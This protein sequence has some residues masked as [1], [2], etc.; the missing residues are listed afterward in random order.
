MMAEAAASGASAEIAPAAAIAALV[1]YKGEV[2]FGSPP[3]GGN[4]CPERH[5][6]YLARSACSSL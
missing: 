5:G 1:G 3:G 2:L 4:S 6:T